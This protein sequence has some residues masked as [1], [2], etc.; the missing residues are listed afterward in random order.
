MTLA[1]LQVLVRQN[2]AAAHLLGHELCAARWQSSLCQLVEG[3]R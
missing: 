3:L 1:T 2:E